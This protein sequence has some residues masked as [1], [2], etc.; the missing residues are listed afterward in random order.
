VEDAWNN[1]V[2]NHTENPFFLS[3][4]LIGFLKHNLKQGW[5]PLMLVFLKNEAIIGLSSLA[6]KRIFGMRVI[7][8]SLPPSFFPDFILEPQYR[9]VCIEKAYDLLF[10][11]LN[12]QLAI[13]TLPVESPNLEKIKNANRLRYSVI[14]QRGHR[15]IVVKN[16][17]TEFER[18]QG[19]KFKQDLRRTERNLNRVGSWKVSTFN[20]KNQESKIIRQILDIEHSSWKEEWRLKKAMKEDPIFKIVWNGTLRAAKLEEDFNWFIWFLEL[21]ALPIAYVLAIW[22]KRVIYFTKTSHNRWY[23]KF[24]PGVYILNAAMRDIF[25]AGETEKIDFHTDLPFLRT[26]SSSSLPRVS[27]L[28]SKHKILPSLL[29]LWASNRPLKAILI[30]LPSV[31]KFINDLA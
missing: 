20:G 13:L 18:S 26:W 28:V 21:N 31:S 17:W 1:F 16:N 9:D 23:R 29:K 2:R 27:I 22:Y 30:S 10:N 11:K 14:P 19:K 6:T 7:K 24:S 25:N 4:F 12:C 8:F 15:F 5:T 3:S